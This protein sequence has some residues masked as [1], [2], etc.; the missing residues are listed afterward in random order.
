D[1]RLSKCFWFQFD[2]YLEIE[3]GLGSTFF[4]IPVKNEPGWSVDGQAPRVR[5]AAYGVD[6]IADEVRRLRAS[7]SEI[8]LHGIDAWRD[9]AKG[10]EE[11]R[12]VSQVTGALTH[13]VRVHWLFFDEETPHRLDEAGFT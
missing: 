11:R 7:G 2:R 10:A 4:V 1:L 9:S 3:K 8:G 12:C 6:D 5:A 13:G